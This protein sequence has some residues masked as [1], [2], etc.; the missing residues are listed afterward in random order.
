MDAAKH[1]TRCRTAPPTPDKELS[2]PILWVGEGNGNPLQ[3]SCLENPRDGEAW[4][5]AVYGVAQSPTRLKWLSILWVEATYAYFT[6][7]WRCLE[8]EKC[9]EFP[10]KGDLSW[11][12]SPGRMKLSRARAWARKPPRVSTRILSCH[13][14]SL[15][16][17]VSLATSSHVVVS[18]MYHIPGP[19]T[20]FSGFKAFSPCNN[21]VKEVLLSS[22]S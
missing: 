10:R 13:T 6:L 18:S 8:L 17:P 1:P 16:L 5:A 9:S 19:Y 4:W 20:C 7:M 22:P 15:P 14:S 11:H 2:C 3:C 21:L 12:F